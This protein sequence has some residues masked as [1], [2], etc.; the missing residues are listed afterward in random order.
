MIRVFVIFDRSWEYY[1]MAVNYLLYFQSEMEG[2]NLSL[3]LM[4]FVH[5]RKEMGRGLGPSGRRRNHGGR[6]LENI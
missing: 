4:S 6:I 5:K 3:A 2:S 1:G